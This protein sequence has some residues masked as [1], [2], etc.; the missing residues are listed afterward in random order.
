VRRE[1]S[2]DWEVAYTAARRRQFRILLGA[3]LAFHVLAV[4]ALAF[5]PEPASP[6]LGRVISVDLLSLP[7]PAPAKPAPAP[8]K[9]IVLP[10][11][12][13]AVRAKPQPVS[14][15]PRPKELDYDEALSNLRSEM[16]EP[17]PQAPPA[18]VELAASEEVE[19]AVTEGE[20]G[21]TVNEEAR[22][23]V[24]AVKRRLRSQYVTPPEFLNR[25]LVTMLQVLLTAEGEVLGT[26]EVVLGSGDPFWDDNAIRTVK[27][28][29]P[30]PPPPE[31]GTWTFTFSSEGR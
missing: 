10:K 5:V 19:A 28:A 27:K 3:S 21:A 13:P 16:G 2:S 31:A 24:G 6:P 11:K 29:S 9:K 15:P 12:A 7:A 18:E 4:S 20:G 17:E 8:P 23:W 14:R 30:L 25:A 22:A 1:W 26:P